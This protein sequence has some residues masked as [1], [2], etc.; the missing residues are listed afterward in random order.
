MRREKE[1][2]SEIGRAH[3]FTPSSNPELGCGHV[4]NQKK[5]WPLVFRP[6][7]DN[8]SALCRVS[9]EITKNQNEY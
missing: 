7:L 1:S 5:H 9:E 4:R 3:V 8:T 6:L 2:E